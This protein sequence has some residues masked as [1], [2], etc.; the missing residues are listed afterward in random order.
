[1]LEKKALAT[2]SAVYGCAKGMKYAYLEKRSTTVSITLLPPTFGSASMK[3]MEMSS[4]TRDG[5]VK[6]CNK[7]TG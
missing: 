2:D 4:Q 7:L 1:M 6:G 5:T 3:S